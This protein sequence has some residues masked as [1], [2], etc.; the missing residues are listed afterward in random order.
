[1]QP[2]DEIVVAQT[3][4]GQIDQRIRMHGADHLF[5]RLSVGSEWVDIE[6]GPGDPFDECVHMG[7][8]AFHGEVQARDEEDIGA[9]FVVKAL[10]FQVFSNILVGREVAPVFP[11]VVH[12]L[13][14]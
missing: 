3:S 4:H 12:I 9:T 14:Q 6:S 5:A 1:M 2:S 10:L 11:V 13:Q 8:V 7:P